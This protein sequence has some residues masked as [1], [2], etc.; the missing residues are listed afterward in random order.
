ML[1]EENVYF[2]F[3]SHSFQYQESSIGCV[4]FKLCIA[5][6]T[7]NNFLSNFTL[8]ALGIIFKFS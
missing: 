2:T 8:C 7:E 1:L 6:K 4:N 5:E 3:N